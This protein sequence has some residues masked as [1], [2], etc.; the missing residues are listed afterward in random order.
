[1]HHKQDIEVSVC[2]VAYNHEA[3][4]AQCLES[5]LNQNTAFKF[6]IIVGEDCSS[7]CTREILKDYVRLYPDII[8]PIYHEKN[9]GAVENIKSVYRKAKGKYI[10]HL[11]GDDLAL[12]NKLQRQFDIL[13]QNK[14]CE[15]C[16][17]NMR[18]IDAA[19]KNIGEWGHEEGKFDLD[20]LYEHLPFFAHSSKMFRNDYKFIYFDLL[21]PQ[22]LD[23]EIHIEQARRGAIYHIDEILGEYRV[24]VGVSTINKKINPILPLGL[25]RVFDKKLSEEKDIL[26]IKRLKKIYAKRMLCYAEQ[27]Y[28]T[29]SDYEIYSLISKKSLTIKLCRISQIYYYFIALLPRFFYTK[30]TNKM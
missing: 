23:L 10:Y 9:V 8:V 18:Y 1:M 16:S 28:E 5:L 2:I 29:G 7:D 27:F 4:L 19:G 17:H 30:L 15:L 11:D 13:E 12:G 6:E 14:D 24:D 26:M 22:A 20:Y 21:H 3:Y 25:M